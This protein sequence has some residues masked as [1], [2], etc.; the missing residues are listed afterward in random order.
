MSKAE[1]D[2]RRYVRHREEIL[3]QKK[4]RYANDEEF[5]TQ[6]KRSARLRRERKLAATKGRDN[7]HRR[8]TLWQRPRLMSLMIDGQEY[9]VYMYT[10]RL[11]ADRMNRTKQSIVKLE[12][13]GHIPVP[14]WIDEHGT[15]LYT[16]DQVAAI[17]KAHNYC[18][19]HEKNVWRW[20]DSQ[21]RVLVLHGY[22]KLVRGV[23]MERYFS[24]QPSDEEEIIGSAAMDPAQ[25]QD[26]ISRIAKLPVYNKQTDKGEK[27]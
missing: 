27:T 19:I 22:S 21:F 5:R 8:V 10:V 4:E 12:K 17:E 18:L 16:E 6:V 1:R 3:Q 14:M 11:L 23:D 7:I 20:K 13:Q 25:V 24:M 9:V 15:R 26:E 2:R